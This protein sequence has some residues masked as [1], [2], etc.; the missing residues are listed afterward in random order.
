MSALTTAGIGT[1]AVSSTSLGATRAVKNTPHPMI[2]APST[3]RRSACTVTRTDSPAVKKLSAANHVNAP[4]NMPA[5]AKT[6]ATH[7]AAAT[8]KSFGART[9]KAAYVLAEAGMLREKY[10]ERQ[11]NGK[12]AEEQVR[13]LARVE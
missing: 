3:R 7:P 8:Q 1:P 12:Q 4:R 9:P 13:A 5:S 10:D 11:A 6:Y 2:Q